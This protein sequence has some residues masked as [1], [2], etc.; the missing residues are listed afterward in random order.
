LTQTD[1]APRPEPASQNLALERYK[2]TLD[3]WKFVLVSGFAAILIAL[4]PALF[5]YATAILEDARKA[6]EATLEDAR[7]ARDAAQSKATFHDTYI[8]DFVQMGLNQD[9]EIRI[10]LATYFAKLSD[11]EYKKGWTDY[12]NDLIL[13][14]NTIRT[15]I[16]EGE[17]KL[18]DL[19]R[20]SGPKDVTM[21]MQLQRELGW[22]Y[23]ELGYAPP[24]KD[25]SD[26]MLYSFIPQTPA[27]CLQR[28]IDRP[29][30]EG[31]ANKAA[32]ASKARALGAKFSFVTEWVTDPKTDP[33][34]LAA[35]AHEIGC[36]SIRIIN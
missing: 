24:N 29:D 33:K 1:D 23:G 35:V 27:G 26:V 10:R 25:V 6:R 18:A 5:Q 34:Q 31:S 4:L 15:E 7:K 32:V 3:F 20:S 2:A 16:D 21:A 12:L 8:K 30:P 13:L 17:K 28:F 11:D 22:K 36:G 19:L 14:R 9:I